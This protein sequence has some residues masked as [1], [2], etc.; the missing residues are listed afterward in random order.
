MLV[1]GAL[2]VYF[3][4]IVPDNSRF[5]QFGEL[6]KER[7]A[8]LEDYAGTKQVN[9]DLG[10]EINQVNPNLFPYAQNSNQ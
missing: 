5:E 9:V 4:T 6:Y 10:G 7:L 1:Y 3:S 2:K 8:L